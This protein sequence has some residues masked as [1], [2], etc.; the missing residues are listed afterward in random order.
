MSRLLACLLS[1]LL[2]VGAALA[3]TSP[4]GGGSNGSGNPNPEAQSG[5]TLDDVLEAIESGTK[6]LVRKIQ[7][8]EARD[9]VENPRFDG[10]DSPRQTVMTFADA[11]DLVRRGYADL[12]YERALGSLPE[13]ATRDDADALQSVLLRLGPISPATLPGTDQVEQSGDARYEFFPQGTDHLWVWQELEEPPTGTITVTRGEDARWLFSEA[14]MAGLPGLAEAMTPLPP[15]YGED[16]G[17][18]YF[19]KAVSPLWEETG[20]VGWLGFAGLTAIGIA[21]GVGVARLIR[22]L[23]RRSNENDR[24]MIATT[25]TGLGASLG[26]LVFT[27]AFTVALGFLTL[28]PVLRPLRFEVPRFLLVVAL[29]M[30]IV[31]LID[32]VAAFARRRTDDQTEKGQYDEMVIAALRRI[33][34]TVVFAVALLF[35][36]QNVFGVN[37][38]ALLLG[39][40]VVALA[41]SLAAQ[42]TVKN[43]FGAITIFVNRPFV[44]GDWIQFDGRMGRH[45]G[46]VEEISLQAVKLKDITG[47]V[48]TIPNMQFIDREVQN[49]SAREHIRREVNIAIPYR[50]D[51]READRAMEALMDV[52]TDEEVVADAK[53][54]GRDGQPHV[55]FAEF[56]EAWLTIRGYHY[57]YMGDE[58][59]DVQRST[60]RGYLSWLDH[61]TM[62]NRKIV[63]AFGARDI[64]FAFPTQTVELIR[65]DDRA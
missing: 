36:L 41:L 24:G 22:W 32:T 2:L 38:G 4:S 42:D 25:L 23:A 65:G 34:R 56:A 15:R 21:L 30:L 5:D 54:H 11:M 29:T 6:L 12:G 17:G 28:G 16:D 9:L 13:G 19:V 50:P 26:T 61:C 47:N 14:T 31:S 43:L 51:A 53:T 18:A 55:S 49:L 58:A 44:I 45:W 3:Q 20:L 64:E 63:D 39:F 8:G 59:E 57:Y 10:Q 7:P 62:V 60:D 1:T 52:F 40:G 33:V 27:I 48:V 35:L 37:V 46:T